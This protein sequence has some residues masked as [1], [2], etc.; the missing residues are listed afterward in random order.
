MLCL[1][2][3]SRKPCPFLPLKSEDHLSQV[4]LFFLDTQPCSAVVVAAPLQ[5]LRAPCSARACQGG[6][7]GGSAMQAG[8]DWGS[9]W[10]PLQVTPLEGGVQASEHSG[11]RIRVSV[12]TTRVALPNYL[13]DHGGQLGTLKNGDIPTDSP[14]LQLLKTWHCN[15]NG[16]FWQKSLRTLHYY[17]V[18]TNKTPPFKTYSKEVFS[19]LLRQVERL[20]IILWCWQLNAELP[21]QVLCTLVAYGK[22]FRIKM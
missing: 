20:Q 16:T 2:S 1:F 22:V 6:Q 17:V 12:W 7:G 3:T 11:A 5:Y 14:N 8:Q 13:N 21:L 9:Q 18:L 19:P 15:L 10:N 4:N